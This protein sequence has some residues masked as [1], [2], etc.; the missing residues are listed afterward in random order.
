MLLTVQHTSDSTFKHLP[1]SQHFLSPGYRNCLSGFIFLFHHIINGFHHIFNPAAPAGRNLFFIMGFY[2][3]NGFCPG[4]FP[5]LRYCTNKPVFG[6]TPKGPSKKLPGTNGIHLDIPR[7]QFQ[8]KGLGKANASE[9][10]S[11]IGKVSVAAF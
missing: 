4:T 10:A 11:G 5:V 9:F 6:I 8:G 3:L 2:I 7:H 1:L